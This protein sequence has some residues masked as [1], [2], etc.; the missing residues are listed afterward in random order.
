VDHI[1]PD[2]ADFITTITPEVILCTKEAN[3]K[4]RALAYQLL[5]RMGHVA[6]SCYGLRPE[7]EWNSLSLIS[8]P[9]L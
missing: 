2:S 1:G 5:V 9:S 6:Q 8:P 4:C 7:G 3:E